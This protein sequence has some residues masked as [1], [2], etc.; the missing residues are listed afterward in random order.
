MVDLYDRTEG[1]SLGK[2]CRTSKGVSYSEPRLDSMASM[3]SY[4]PR[5]EL[6]RFLNEISTVKIWNRYDDS[7][8][9]MGIADLSSWRLLTGG[10]RSDPEFWPSCVWASGRCLGGPFGSLSGRPFR[11]AVWAAL[12]GRCLGGPFGP[13]SGRPFRAGVWVWSGV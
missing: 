13:L 4:P 5:H 2:P 8:L 11:V 6:S 12:S 3:L 1:T 9:K 7:V 10:N